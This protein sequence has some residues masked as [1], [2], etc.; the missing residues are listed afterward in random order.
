M[1]R[2]SFILF[3]LIATFFSCKTKYRYIHFANLNIENPSFFRDSIKKWSFTYNKKYF[4]TKELD[5]SGIVVQDKIFEDFVQKNFFNNYGNDDKY[6]YLGNVN[7]NKNYFSCLFYRIVEIDEANFSRELNVV[8]FNDS[9]ILSRCNLSAYIS[10]FTG[11]YYD[12]SKMRRNKKFVK[13]VHIDNIRCW[14]LWRSF[15]RYDKFYF[16]VDNHGY[17]VPK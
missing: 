17:I 6:Y 2:A 9:I 3:L 16:K 10:S 7:L 1:S 5:T 15:T 4:E 14:L 12:F 11:R 8:N 13:Y